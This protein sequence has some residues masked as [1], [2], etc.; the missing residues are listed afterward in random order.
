MNIK[1]S[2]DEHEYLK[3]HS[4]KTFKFGSSLYNLE[5]KKSDLDLFCIYDFKKLET[6]SYL[7]NNHTFQFTENNIDYIYSTHNQFLQNLYSGDSIINS[8]I[9]INYNLLEINTIRTYKIIKA[10][11]GYAKRDINHCIN[12]SKDKRKRIL[13]AYKSL[14]IAECLLYQRKINTE[15]IKNYLINLDLELISNFLNL[16]QKKNKELLDYLNA[17]FEKNRIKKYPDFNYI[18]YN[19]ESNLLTLLLNSN[20]IKEFKY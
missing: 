17:E 9:V 16:A 10:H 4:Y 7:P 3:E 18:N 13:L 8:E 20:N 15:I 19:I 5:T 11:L 12:N 2:K 1:I 6:F 14:F